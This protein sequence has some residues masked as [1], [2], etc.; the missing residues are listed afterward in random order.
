MSATVTL[1]GAE[2]MMAVN[3]LVAAASELKAQILVLGPLFPDIPGAKRRIE[4]MERLAVK[5]SPS[6]FDLEE[7]G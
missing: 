2:Q 6:Q 7:M 5:L 4:A 1:T 3:A